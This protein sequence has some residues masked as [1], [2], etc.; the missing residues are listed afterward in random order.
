MI[1]SLDYKYFIFPLLTLI[2]YI[3]ESKESIV[4]KHTYLL[5]IFLIF[6]LGFSKIGSDYKSYKWI[7]EAISSGVDL[8]YIHGE[9]LYKQLNLLFSNF[10]FEFEFFKSV[11]LGV[12][13]LLMYKYIEKLSISVPY[14]LFL[15][16]CFYIIYLCSAFRQLAAM[17]ACIAGFY[18]IRKNKGEIAILINIIALFIHSSSIL[19]L[20]YFIFLNFKKIKVIKKKNIFW[21]ILI[22]S[23]LLRVTA[24]IFI[25][26]L[27]FL[28]KIIGFDNQFSSY[29]NTVTI[30][31][32]G[33]LARLFTAIVLICNLK[34]LSK[35]K[36]IYNTYIFYFIGTIVYLIIPLEL[37]TAR[38]TNNSKI[39]EIFL[40]PYLIKRQKIFM[41]KVILSILFILLGLAIFINHLLKQGGY[42]PY[43]NLYF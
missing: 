20:S 35:N 9:I 1:N 16:Y 3:F 19:P 11:Y 40:I 37:L 23:L 31:S 33:L 38:L 34:I 25:P 41:N 4:K 2:F 14:S 5:G 27:S 10:G 30:L 15:L 7:Y 12:L 17:V 36:L 6:F 29:S 24:G 42:Y 8:N 43:Q 18:Y 21:I 22:I 28:F 13:L 39:M 32:I 26:K